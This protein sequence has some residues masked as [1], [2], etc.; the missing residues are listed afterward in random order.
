MVLKATDADGESDG[1]MSSSEGGGASAEG[2]GSRPEGVTGLGELGTAKIKGA[3]TVLLSNGGGSEGV[4][5]PVRLC[6]AVG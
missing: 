4:P 2:R 1:T 3:S 6:A 5:G